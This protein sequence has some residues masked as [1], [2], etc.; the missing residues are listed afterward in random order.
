[1][2]S[3][4]VPPFPLISAALLVPVG[5]SCSMTTSAHWRKNCGNGDYDT[6]IGAKGSCDIMGFRESQGE[7]TRIVMTRGPVERDKKKPG[8]RS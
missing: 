8:G 2:R 4:V 7:V 1:M 3:V 6:L 5:L